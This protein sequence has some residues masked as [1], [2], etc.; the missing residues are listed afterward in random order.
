MSF[1][2]FLGIFRRSHAGPS[3][4]SIWYGSDIFRGSDSGPFQISM[5]DFLT[6][7]GRTEI[8]VPGSPF[9]SCLAWY[10]TFFRDPSKSTFW[11]FVYIFRGI[12]GK[13]LLHWGRPVTVLK[14]LIHGEGV[15]GMGCWNGEQDE[16]LLWITP[17][18]SSLQ[19]SHSSI[20]KASDSMGCLSTRF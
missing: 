18:H 3:Q 7:P 12:P 1:R 11:H 5:W 14:V 6:C 17:C 9:D 13:P 16:R 15:Q 8:D 2:Y 4:M 19:S 10:W 20:V